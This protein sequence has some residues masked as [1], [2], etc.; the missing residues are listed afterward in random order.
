VSQ[1]SEVAPAP[2]VFRPLRREDLPLVGRWLAEPL[3]A[4][5]WHD[6]ASPQGVEE[7]F[8]PCIA[9]REPTEV[10]LALETGRPFG[11]IQRY[12]LAAYPDDL[13]QLSAL[14]DVPPGALSIDYLVGEPD[15][16]GRGLGAAMITAFV[17]L[18]WAAHP[19][20]P[21]VV[22]AVAAGNRA[23]WRSLERAGFRR[24][25]EGDLPPDN[26]TDPP[27]HVVHRLDRPA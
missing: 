13:A 26:P 22:V 15:A 17:A 3:V 4:R 21:A 25:A 7:Q 20:A 9:G 6:D 11:L 14:C 23:S 1:V 18:T 19:H 10:F 8:G 16:R 12:A 27:L 5:W 24:V 2:V